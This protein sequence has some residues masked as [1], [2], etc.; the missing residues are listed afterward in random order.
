[1]QQET[2]S[3]F[4]ATLMLFGTMFVMVIGGLLC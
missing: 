2:L 1:M 3:E 4:F